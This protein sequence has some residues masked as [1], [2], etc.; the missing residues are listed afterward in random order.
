MPVTPS[1]T[2][3]ANKCSLRYV[4]EFDYRYS[5]DRPPIN[6][7]FFKEVVEIVKDAGPLWG[8]GIERV[9]NFVKKKILERKEKQT[10][11]LRKSNK[12]LNVFGNGSFL[13]Y[14][15]VRPFFEIP[16]G[17]R[18]YF[19][20]VRFQNKMPRNA[21]PFNLQTSLVIPAGTDLVLQNVTIVYNGELGKF[22]KEYSAPSVFLIRVNGI[23]F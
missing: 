22:I 12:I 3:L 17:S 23:A 18:L 6:E 20:D 15:D 9:Y 16:Q 2:N 8:F 21:L 7:A 10:L 19:Y 11:E 4:Q 14:G 1:I 5:V 13:L